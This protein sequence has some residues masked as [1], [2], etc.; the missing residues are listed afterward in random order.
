MDQESRCR[1]LRRQASAQATLCYMGTQLSQRDI[2]LPKFW[3]MSIVAKRLNGLRCHLCTEVGLGQV[4]KK[5]VQQP[6][7]SAMSIAAKRLDEPRYHL[8]R[9]NALAQAT[10]C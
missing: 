8:V 2:T 7:F 1:L 6:L 9:R 3:P 5:E 4:A 10:L